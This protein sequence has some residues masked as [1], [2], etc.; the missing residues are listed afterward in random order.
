M[1]APKIT[2]EQIDSDANSTTWL[3]MAENITRIVVFVF[4]LLLPVRLQDGISKIGLAIYLLGTLLYFATWIPIIWMHDSS[5]SQCAAGLLAPRLTPLLPLLGIALIGHSVPYA[6][7]SALFIILH[8][9]HG[10]QN[11]RILI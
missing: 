8:T 7:V 5:W 3:L 10:V 11:L 2:L 9:W 1:L 6:V 4:P